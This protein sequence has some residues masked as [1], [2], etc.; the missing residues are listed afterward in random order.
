MSKSDKTVNI[1]DA[2]RG[3]N[4][5]DNVPEELAPVIDWWRENGSQFLMTICIVV[6][7]CVAASFFARRRAARA[8]AASAAIVSGD[9]I[10]SLELAA[11]Q[12]G[13]AKAGPVIKAEL[14]KSYYD[15]GRYD[16]ALEQYK[17][18]A[19]SSNAEVAAIAKV[20]IAECLEAKNDPD[21]AS[22][23]YDAFLAENPGS[24][25]TPEA[26]MG[27]ARCLA[28]AGD[29]DGAKK[30]LED[31]AVAKRDTAWEKTA[32]DLA[33]TIGNFTGLKAE[34]VAPSYMDLLS[35]QIE[36]EDAKNETAP[37]EET[38]AAEEA[39]AADEAPV[40]DE[41]PAAEAAP[42]PAE[43]PAAEEAAAPA[44]AAPAPAEEPAAEEAAAPAEAA[45]APAE[46]QP[47]A[48]APAAE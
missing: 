34:P 11:G 9:S 28:L 15:A 6:I 8:E 3:K 16:D 19:K 2:E 24:W 36:A 1:P 48:E 41:A 7:A 23:A 31:L 26:T 44:E 47:A 42:A 10:E 20:G 37:A 38:P 12:Y 18:L 40:A 33:K 5:P 17:A 43:E 21:G 25:L 4:L 45:P 32:N 22:K 30:I 27:K 14:A 46:G 39:P 13:S 35:S 29:K